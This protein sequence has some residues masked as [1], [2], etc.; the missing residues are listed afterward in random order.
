M[1]SKSIF[2]YGSYSIISIQSKHLSIQW[3]FYCRI[4]YL[5]KIRRS[6]NTRFHTVHAK[7]NSLSKAFYIIFKLDQQRYP[8]DKKMF[9]SKMRSLFRCY[10]YGSPKL[11]VTM[12]T[13]STILLTYYVKKAYDTFLYVH[14][15]EA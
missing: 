9:L 7:S 6:F 12:C 4:Q 13:T 5:C 8:L 10:G 14:R 15:A 2:E 1:Y 11:L 3:T